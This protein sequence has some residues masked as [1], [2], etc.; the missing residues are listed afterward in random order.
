MFKWNQ[1][2]ALI[3]K[4]ALEEKKTK[5]GLK[6]H[7]KQSDK[8]VETMRVFR[9]RLDHRNRSCRRQGLGVNTRSALALAVS[10]Y[11]RM[12]KGKGKAMKT[13]GRKA[14]LRL[15]SRIKSAWAPQYRWVLSFM[16]HGLDAF[17]KIV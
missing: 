11:T 1:K 13:L 2:S 10:V 4:R 6:Q 3:R 16:V 15:N 5:L 9:E 7:N 8:V 12:E 14:T 17:K